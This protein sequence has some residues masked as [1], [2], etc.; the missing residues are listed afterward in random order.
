MPVM[1]MYFP[2]EQ[3]VAMT[4]MVHLLNNLF[5]FSLTFRHLDKRVL[6][7]FGVTSAIFALFGALS[8]KLIGDFGVMGNW[9]C[10]GLSGELSM[11][12][13]TMALI[14]LAFVAIDFLPN[15]KVS[16]L[17]IEIGGALSG[18]FGGLSGHQGAL[19]SAFLWRYGLSKEA[20]VASGIGIACMIDLTRIPVYLIQFKANGMSENTGL[21]GACCL[22][23]F[24]GA[25]LGNKYLKK[26]TLQHV[27]YV[28]GGCLLIMAILLGLGIV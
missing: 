17:P 28:V 6:L 18:F 8:L 3:A 2:L 19:R 21:I 9:S 26:A 27:Q 15:F 20:F 16:S 24:A 7:R 10:C 22:S 12:K 23:A 14:L 25:W 4:A 5:K 1:A 13:I 11:L